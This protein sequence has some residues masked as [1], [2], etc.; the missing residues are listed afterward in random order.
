MTRIFVVML[1]LATF[2]FSAFAIGAEESEESGP[3]EMAL[4]K[5]AC[6]SLEDAR[7]ASERFH[8]ML[9]LEDI[10]S[11]RLLSEEEK[12]EQQGILNTFP[13]MIMSQTCSLVRE[14]DVYV[15][16]GILEEQ[17][18]GDGRVTVEKAQITTYVVTVVAS[19][20]SNEP[21]DNADAA[22]LLEGGAR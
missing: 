20:A 13:L 12:A 7:R 8:R 14:D 22:P 18:T 5:L 9:I 3:A 11:K 15:S 17:D 2:T 4:I 19:L 16:Q 6:K 21:A 10:S 1:A